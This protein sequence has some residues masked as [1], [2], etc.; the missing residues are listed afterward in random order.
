VTCLNQVQ[1]RFS[2]EEARLVSNIQSAIIDYSS[3]EKLRR[4]EPK[5]SLKTM[6]HQ[7]GNE[8]MLVPTT[9]EAT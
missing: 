1:A 5:L 7:G 3:H 2:F 4:V 9:E 8:A 6:C